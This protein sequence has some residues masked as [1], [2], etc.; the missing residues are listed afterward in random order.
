MPPTQDSQTSFKPNLT[1]IFLSARYIISNP[2]GGP[3]TAC[4]LMTKILLLHKSKVHKLYYWPGSGLQEFF[5]PVR[6]RYKSLIFLQISTPNKY[7]SDKIL[8]KGALWF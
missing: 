4:L 2:D 6:L 5:K 1:C 8:S 7:I 3:C